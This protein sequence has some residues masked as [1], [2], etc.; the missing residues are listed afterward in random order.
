MSNRKYLN[1]IN[2]SAMGLIA[3]NRTS[4][5]TRRSVDVILGDRRYKLEASSSGHA[6]PHGVD[7]DF[8]TAIF[9]LALESGIPDDNTLRTTPTELLRTAMIT[10][11]GRDYKRL[12]DSLLRIFHATYVIRDGWF[13]AER[14]K[15]TFKN[16]TFRFIDKL[17][18]EDEE[19]LNAQAELTANGTLV[20]RLNEDVVKQLKA[21]YVHLPDPAVLKALRDAPSRALYHFLEAQRER[22]RKDTGS[23]PGTL[24]FTL[25]GIS[26]L[27]A[28][29]GDSETPLAHN[30]RR[31]LR[32]M[33]EAL[34]GAGC[35]KEAVLDGRGWNGNITF[36]FPDLEVQAVADPEK[37]DRLVEQGLLPASARQLA[38]KF[39]D[40][41][42]TGIRI[43]QSMV[44][45]YRRRG[46]EPKDRRALL[47]A[48]VR[49]PDNYA[50]VKLLD[51]DDRPAPAVK[52][53]ARAAR[54]SAARESS[55]AY[56]DEVEQKNRHE[57]DALD[58]S[59]QVERF[60]RT[61][62]HLKV[63]CPTADVTWLRA[64]GAD[65]YTLQKAMTAAL[66][67]GKTP[68]G[69]FED[70]LSAARSQATPPLFGS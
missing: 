12:R 40:N 41:V 23:L 56:A 52:P 1:E 30:I 7:S 61:V 3:A 70:A 64:Q 2:R 4:K 53:A 47:A 55:E 15:W 32:R 43:F 69:V 20:I 16:E 58:A 14:E 13:D 48:I 50:Q 35:L 11:G 19:D 6:L 28:L 45:D 38:L 9:T 60:I 29:D 33:S 44:A 66:F 65:L 8:L 42:E 5:K 24:S 18:W 34:H 25:L 31:D 39:P 67:H 10:T 22:E 63:K 59:T 21:G 37:V 26:N 54:E 27:L 49:T 68:Q 62:G 17:S 57:W 36:T 46:R 51:L